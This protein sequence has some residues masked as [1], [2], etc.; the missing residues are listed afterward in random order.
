[1]SAGALVAVG[2][3]VFFMDRLSIILCFQR[4]KASSGL[5]FVVEFSEGMNDCK[6]LAL[7]LF[8][9]LFIGT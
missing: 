7:F 4:L 5:Y 2:D 9:D 3:F 8:G 6:E 1:M